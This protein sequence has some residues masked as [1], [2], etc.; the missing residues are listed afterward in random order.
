M[1][2][3]MKL[4]SGSLRNLCHIIAS[5]LPAVAVH[6]MLTRDFEVVRNENIAKGYA[7]THWKQNFT[8]FSVFFVYSYM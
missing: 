7:N 1:I 5:V 8:F 3:Y 6:N 2:F 4:A